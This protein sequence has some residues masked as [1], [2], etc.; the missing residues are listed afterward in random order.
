MPHTHTRTFR[1]RHYECD[2]YGHLNNANYVRYMQETAFD[3]SAAVGYSVARYAEMGRMWLVRHTDIEYLHPLRYNNSVQV[4]TWVADFR[5]AT[6]RRM[7]EFYRDDELCA[8]ASTD[9]AFLDT[10]TRRP[11]V[12]PP[13]L[14]NAFFP[15]GLPPTDPPREKFPP[16][17]PP[18]QGVFTM[19]RRV[20]WSDIGPARHVNNAVYLA[21]LDDCGMQVAAAFGWPASRMMAEGFGIIA[22]RHRIEY[23][24]SALLDDDLEI[25]TWVSH[26]KR[27]TAFRHYAIT[28]P[29]DDTLIARARTLYVWVNLNTGQPVRI[30]AQFLADFAPNIYN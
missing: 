18:P 26:V 14:I 30:P 29:G 2:A 7:Y 6:S 20:G 5:R 15:E 22:R 13:E 12:I 17:P 27:A 1:V 25:T 23:K 10:A 9:W 11:V 8:K 3:A 28:R 21:Y 16:P 4:K 19:P 24:Q